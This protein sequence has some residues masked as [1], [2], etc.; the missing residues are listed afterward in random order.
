MY[1]HKKCWVFAKAPFT[2]SRF[3]S[4]PFNSLKVHHRFYDDGKEL[5]QFSALFFAL[6]LWILL[7]W[8]RPT[9]VK[10]EDDEKNESKLIRIPYIRTIYLMIRRPSRDW[11][12]F[13]VKLIEWTEVCGKIA[14]FLELWHFLD[15]WKFSI[16]KI[17]TI[18]HF[19]VD[20]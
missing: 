11:N 3:D 19:S 7:K 20:W 9:T 18:W 12:L 13:F 14:G 6:S 5:K 8:I 4:H 16:S 1:G 15:L 2:H 17:N 10:N